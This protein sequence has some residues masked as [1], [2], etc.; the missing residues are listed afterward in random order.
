MKPISVCGKLESTNTL[1]TVSKTPVFRPKS[2]LKILS[3][4][5]VASKF[6]EEASGK[7]VRF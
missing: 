5:I 4:Q 3:V 2:A 7:E 1:E 6:D